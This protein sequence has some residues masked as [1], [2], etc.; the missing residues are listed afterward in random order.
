MATANDVILYA[1]GND[2]M[3]GPLTVGT[4]KTGQH[5]KA[6]QTDEFMVTICLAKACQ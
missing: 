5:F 6:G 4:G 2:G 3:V 1:Y